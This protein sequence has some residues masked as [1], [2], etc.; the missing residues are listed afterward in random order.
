M[1]VFLRILSDLD[2]ESRIHKQ[3]MDCR[4]ICSLRGNIYSDL[5]V[6]IRS[7]II[8]R[9]HKPVWRQIGGAV[10]EILNSMVDWWP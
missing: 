10:Y 4:E 9:S 6:S 5:V 3:L 8:P 7:D 1:L 2:L